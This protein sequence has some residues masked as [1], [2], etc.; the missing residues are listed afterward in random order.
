MNTIPEPV[1]IKKVVDALLE[2]DQPFPAQYLHIFSDISKS[3]LRAIGKIWGAIPV[4]RR[5]NLLTDLEILMESDTLVLCDEMAKFALGDTDPNIRSRAIKL[6]WECNDPNLAHRFLD[7][8][9]NDPNIIVQNTAAMALGKFILLGELDEVPKVLYE[10]INS[11][12]IEI[13]RSDISKNVKQ[14]ILKSLGYT[15]NPQIIS[16]I[17]ESYKN[18]D[19]SWQLAAVI[20]MGRSA[21]DRWAKEILEKL[22]SPDSFQ[23]I[24]FEAVIAAGDLEIQAARPI[25]LEMFEEDQ[26]DEDINHQIIWSLSK[27]GG[28]GA[29]QALEKRLETSSNEDEIEVLEMAIDNLDFTDQLPDLDI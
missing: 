15:S 9:Q 4:Q 3:D 1:P 24:R 2:L 7:L 21:D 13:F 8:L 12:L 19:L 26:E 10:T 5:I 22:E 25:L 27:I 20:A 29:R 11:S 28:E 17:K 14:E 23:P 16:M 6:L 18:P